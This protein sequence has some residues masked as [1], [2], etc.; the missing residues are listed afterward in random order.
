VYEVKST[1]PYTSSNRRQRYRLGLWLIGEEA[2]APVPMVAEIA[3]ID[4][5]AA[6]VQTFHST[7]MVTVYAC[8][9]DERPFL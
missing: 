8:P 1:G 9:K 5:V 3:K 6:G 2:T 7:S 4:P